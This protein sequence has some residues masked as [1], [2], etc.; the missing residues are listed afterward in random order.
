M[1]FVAGTAVIVTV[2]M[3]ASALAGE[4]VDADRAKQG[5]YGFDANG[6][7]S[8]SKLSSRDQAQCTLQMDSALSEDVKAEVRKAYEARLITPASELEDSLPP[9]DE[10]VKRDLPP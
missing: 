3:G 2:L 6:V 8:S 1:R 10:R 7:C 4:P 5:Y 9:H